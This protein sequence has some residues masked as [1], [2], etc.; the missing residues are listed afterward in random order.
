MFRLSRVAVTYCEH[1]S[2]EENEEGTSAATSALSCGMIVV[3]KIPFVPLT[4]ST[5]GSEQTINVLSIGIDVKRLHPRRSFFIIGHTR[6]YMTE[7]V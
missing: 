7:F 1:V 5:D 3:P 4:S 6:L 2:D